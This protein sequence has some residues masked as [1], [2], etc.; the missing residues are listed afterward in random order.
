MT[1]LETLEARLKPQYVGWQDQY[2][3]VLTALGIPLDMPINDLDEL[4]A[5][6]ED[7]K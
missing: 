2:K 3:G 6:W 4:M 5:L 7:E 1:V